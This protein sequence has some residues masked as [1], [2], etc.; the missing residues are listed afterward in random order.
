[1]LFHLFKLRLQSGQVNRTLFYRLPLLSSNFRRLDC[2][3]VEGYKL[4]PVNGPI[5][6]AILI[7]EL[8]GKFIEHP[9]IGVLELFAFFLGL[10]TEWFD[11][12]DIEVWIARNKLPKCLAAIFEIVAL[13]G[14]TGSAV[15]AAINGNNLFFSDER[16]RCSLQRRSIRR[17]G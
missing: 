9:V 15:T 5:V 3:G 16:C 8:N 1:M 14:G 2:R 17:S 4:V 6:V 7:P 12:L 10:V 11:K 13:I